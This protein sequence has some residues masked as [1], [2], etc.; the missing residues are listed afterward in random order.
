MPTEQA[1]CTAG[2]PDLVK[3]AVRGNAVLTC[4]QHNVAQRAGPFLATRELCD[5][6]VHMCQ[7]VTQPI[8]R[9][10]SGHTTANIKTRDRP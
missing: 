2:T 5:L 7:A 10:V 8:S 3:H 9:H 4:K 6:N 1:S